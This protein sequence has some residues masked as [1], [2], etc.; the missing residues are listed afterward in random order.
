MNEEGVTKNVLIKSL[1]EGSSED[2]STI[3][4]YLTSAI[5]SSNELLASF[6][7]TLKNDLENAR[8]ELLS[9]ER[10]AATA[11]EDYAKSTSVNF[12]LYIFYTILPIA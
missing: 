2:I 11:F 4:L 9:F 8:Q 7:K 5:S 10:S 3:D 1:K 12:N 6:A